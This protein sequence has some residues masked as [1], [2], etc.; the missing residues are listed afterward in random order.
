MLTFLSTAKT[1]AKP[2][3]DISTQGIHQLAL[4]RMSVNVLLGATK[5]STTRSTSESGLLSSGTAEVAELMG[6]PLSRTSQPRRSRARRNCTIGKRPTVSGR[7][8]VDCHPERGLY[9]P[10]IVIPS[11]DFSPSRGICCSHLAVS[12]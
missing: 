8:L 12:A 5:V 1:S 3:I 2:K 10:K 4:R 7:F 11:E 9:F 6:S